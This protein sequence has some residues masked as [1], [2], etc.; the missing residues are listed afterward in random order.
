MKMKN[1]QYVGTCKKNNVLQCISS[2]NNYKS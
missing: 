1:F 2:A